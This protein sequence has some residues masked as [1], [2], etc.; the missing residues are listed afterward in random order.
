MEINNLK[1]DNVLTIEVSGRL[2]S[3]TAVM[4]EENIKNNLDDNI[5]KL[6]FDFASLEY[7]SSAGLRILL[8]LQKDFNKSQKNMIIKNVKDSVMEVLEITGFTNILTI[9]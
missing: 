6:I 5:T 7:I 1:N 4:L 9:E 8:T 2:D 3:T